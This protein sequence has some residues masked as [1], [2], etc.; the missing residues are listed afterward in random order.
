[1]KRALES[2]GS[3]FAEVIKLNYYCVDRVDPTEQLQ[4]RQIRDEYVDTMAPPASTFVVVSRL[5]R[6]GW[7]IEIEAIAAVRDAV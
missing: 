5:M 1:L 2:A 6:P 7:L 3:S 4:F